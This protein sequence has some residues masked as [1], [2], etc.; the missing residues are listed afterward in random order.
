M[1]D[2]KTT[3]THSPSSNAAPSSEPLSNPTSSTSQ[4]STRSSPPVMLAL[5]RLFMASGPLLIGVWHKAA[6]DMPRPNGRYDINQPVTCVWVGSSEPQKEEPEGPTGTHYAPLPT[7]F[8]TGHAVVGWA[9]VNTSSRQLQQTKKSPPLS[10]VCCSLAIPPPRVIT[11]RTIHGTQTLCAG[12]QLRENAFGVLH[13]AR[14]PGKHRFAQRTGCTAHRG[15]V[16]CAGWI[17]WATQETLTV[18]AVL[19]KTRRRPSSQSVIVRIQNY[20][21]LWGHKQRQSHN[22]TSNG[23]ASVRTTNTNAATPPPP[24]T[25][26][27]ITNNTARARWCEGGRG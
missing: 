25:T 16:T 12:F 5:P 17:G 2:G 18:L 8:C 6:H 22:N 24:Q 20:A 15:S 19:Q 7:L 4:S 14:H 21:K 1:L 26:H 11:C 9:Y 27:N 3:P 13:G 23:H 10:F